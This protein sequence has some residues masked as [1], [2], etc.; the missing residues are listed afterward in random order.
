MTLR[1]MMIEITNE[2]CIDLMA[3]YRSKH[4]DLAIVDPPYGIKIRLPVATDD[5][6]WDVAPS[7]KYFEELFR[8]SKRQIIWGGNYFS[9]KLPPCRCFVIWRKTTASADMRYSMCEYAWTSFSLPSKYFESQPP[10]TAGWYKGNEQR[11]HPTQKPVVLYK[12]LLAQFAKAG[13]RI[14]DTHLGSGSIALACKELGFDL[15]ACEIDKDY[16][17]AAKER[18]DQYRPQ[19]NLFA[20]NDYLVRQYELFD[21][22]E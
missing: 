17:E 19:P 20:T 14:L 16:F 13:W 15:T 10:K 22:A 7:K 6:K 2:N 21:G 18:I 11:V 3:R 5:K 1:A 9:D 12:F 8:V 4:F